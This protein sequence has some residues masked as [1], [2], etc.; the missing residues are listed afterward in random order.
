MD[1]GHSFE[2][3]LFNVI[4]ILVEDHAVESNFLHQF[5]S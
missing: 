3:K 1:A 4:L 5:D 2:I